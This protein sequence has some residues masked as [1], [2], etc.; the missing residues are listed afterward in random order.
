MGRFWQRWLGA[1]EPSDSIPARIR[2]IGGGGHEIGH[3]WRE[4][5]TAQTGDEGGRNLFPRGFDQVY[6]REL[7]SFLGATPNFFLL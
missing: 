5:V 4:V 3:R 1:E 2:G 6:L 7:G